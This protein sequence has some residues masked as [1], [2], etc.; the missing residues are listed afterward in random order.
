MIIEEQSELQGDEEDELEL[1]REKEKKFLRGWSWGRM[2]ALQ[3]A[4]NQVGEMTDYRLD[5]MVKSLVRHLFDSSGLPRSW[6]PTFDIIC[7]DCARRYL[8]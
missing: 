4:G 5:R 1:E 3:N 6:T 7:E 8:K 2:P